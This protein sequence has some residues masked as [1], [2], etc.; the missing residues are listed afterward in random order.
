MA[1]ATRIFS[2]CNPM[3]SLCYDLLTVLNLCGL[4]QAFRDTFTDELVVLE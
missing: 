3:P 2:D 1:S 4:A